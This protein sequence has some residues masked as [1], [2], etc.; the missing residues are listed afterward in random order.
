MVRAL[1][2]EQENYKSKLFHFKGMFDNTGRHSKSLSI[3][4]ASSLDPTPEDDIVSSRS[5]GS[6]PLHHDPERALPN[7]SRTIKEEIV[8]KEAK[9]KHMQGK[10]IFNVNVDY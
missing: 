2:Q 5:Q 4:S 8:A 3:E 6:K 10:Y 1:E 9:E 7:K